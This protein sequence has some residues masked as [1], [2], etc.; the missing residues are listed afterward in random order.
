MIAKGL[1]F[2]VYPRLNYDGRPIA[3]V[4]KIP[5][6]FNRASF[7]FGDSAEIL[8][9]E[10][11]GAKRLVEGT[12]VTIPETTIYRINGKLMRFFPVSSVVVRQ[13]FIQEDRSIPDMLKYLTEEGFNSLAEEY[14]HEP[15]NFISHDRRAYWVDPARGVMGRILERTGLMSLEDYRRIRRRMSKAIRFLGL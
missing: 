15:R 2:A 12:G 6:I 13:T 5:R 7:L 3:D 1:E 9:S 11:V 8:R 4:L 14:R 10:L